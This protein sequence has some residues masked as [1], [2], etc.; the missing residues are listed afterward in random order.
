[1]KTY[2]L[3]EVKT[4]YWFQVKYREMAAGQQRALSDFRALTP[5]VRRSHVC[6]F[7]LQMHCPQPASL[8]VA[9]VKWNQESENPKASLKE[10]VTTKS[11]TDITKINLMYF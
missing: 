4:W 9:N 5:T 3:L 6:H 10:S 1:M 7:L 8:C 2:V 11:K